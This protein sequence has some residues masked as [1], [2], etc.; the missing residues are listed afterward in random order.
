[1]TYTKIK[2]IGRGGFGRVFEVVNAKG[3]RFALKEFEPNNDIQSLI[4]RGFVKGS[5]LKGRFI[6]EVK[7]QSQLDNQHIVRIVDR[8]LDGD[9]PWFVMELAIG[10]LQDD[11]KVDR[12]L[13]GD[14]SRALFDILAGLEDIH[15]RDIV[16]RDLKP[17]NVLKLLNKDGTIRYAISDFGLISSVAAE[18]TTLTQTGHGGG[19]PV[20]AA[21]E[22]ITKFSYATPSADIYSVGAILHDIFDGGNRT[23]YLEQTTDGPCREIIEKC[24]KTNPARRYQSVASL[25]DAIYQELSGKILTFKSGAEKE[26]VEILQDGRALTDNEWDRVYNFI[27]RPETVAQSKKNIFSVLS[28]DHFRELSNSSAELLNALATEFS[29]YARN[30]GHDFDYCDVIADKLEAIFLCGS[31]GIQAHCLISLLVLG[32]DH[33]RWFVENKFL[34]LASPQMNSNIAER[35]ELDIEAEEFDFKT[36]I[37]RM[38]KSI[39]NRT[40]LLHPLLIE[41]SNK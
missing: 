21:P 37:K 20:Y 38:E 8:N 15:K 35:V 10:T 18:T 30:E 12:S 19:T 1:M 31:I 9:K 28:S 26:I 27:N 13:G 4:D 11:L 40:H 23:P 2:E 24:T 39:G 16:H 29:N 14:P 34:R 6:R 25:R 17:V 36:Y 32:V 7:Y 3:E 22:L 41:I 33:N 5:L